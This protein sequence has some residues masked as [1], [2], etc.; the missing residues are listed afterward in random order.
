MHDF[1]VTI[2]VDDA[3]STAT[4]SVTGDFDAAC[5]EHFDARVRSLVG[6]V[7]AIVVD[8]RASTVIDSAALGALIRLAESCAGAGPSF[9]TV[10][11]R[12]FQIELLRITGLAEF[13]S[14]RVD[15]PDR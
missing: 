11:A 4:I 13:L 2:V 15:G 12:P 9:E 14:V 6:A 5:V 7:R 10:V 1:T 8:L 3:R